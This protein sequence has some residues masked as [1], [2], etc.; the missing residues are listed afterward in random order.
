MQL[1][2]F[3]HSILVHLSLYILCVLPWPSALK[4]TLLV[5]EGSLYI[6]YNIGEES[7][8]RPRNTSI[9]RME[10]AA[11]AAASTPQDKADLSK[12][13]D[14]LGEPREGE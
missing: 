10:L 4:Y 6:H 9:M 7:W 12:V 14:V 2:R 1:F 5:S 3:P 13:K 8:G 11:R